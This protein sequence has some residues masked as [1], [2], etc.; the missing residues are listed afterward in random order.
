M[1][2]NFGLHFPS[3]ELLK[4]PSEEDCTVGGGVSEIEYP[5]LPSSDDENEAG[6]DETSSGIRPPPGFNKE[7]FGTSGR[8]PFIR[9]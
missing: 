8:P 2:I 6:T 7:A 1:Y 4:K 5:A 3:Q 9:R